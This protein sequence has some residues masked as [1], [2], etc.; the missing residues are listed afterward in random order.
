[1]NDLLKTQALHYNNHGLTN[2]DR[3]ESIALFS[4]ASFLDPKEP[5][6]MWHMAEAQLDLADM[7]AAITTLRKVEYLLKSSNSKLGYFNKRASHLFFQHGEILLDQF[8]IQEAAGMF[9]MAKSMGY[10]LQRM[11]L[12]LAV[13]KMCLGDIDGAIQS[14]YELIQ[15]F[16][17]LAD[18]Y[19]LR[20]RIHR[21]LENPFLVNLDYLRA[22]ELVQ[23]HSALPDLR[24]YILERAVFYR[25]KT[26]EQIQR[27]QYSSALWYCNQAIELDSK[28]W[29]TQLTRGM[30]LSELQDYDDAL[31]DLQIVKANSDRGNE[32]EMLI[33]QH[34]AAIY[35]KFGVLF[36][37]RK[38]YEEAI[39]LFSTALSYSSLDRIILKNR[40]ECFY[41]L[42]EY[43]LAL[44]DFFT[45][46]EMDKSDTDCNLRISLI[47]GDQGLN[48]ISKGWYFEASQ[49]FTNAI[50]HNKENGDFYYER[51]RS[52]YFQGEIDKAREDLIQ[53]LD[54]DETNTK[55]QGLISILSGKPY[56]DGFQPM[57]P[58]KIAK[59][60]EKLSSPE[61]TIARART[62]GTGALAVHTLDPSDVF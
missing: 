15:C 48:A 12:K 35:N 17:E 4:K 56:M 20:A 29:R 59:Q 42:K 37:Q 34:I 41:R 31:E 11:H 61:D 40:A 10:P 55:A 62:D 28:D 21:L 46:L 25:N 7:P 26:S 9:Y 22:R 39:R 32:K 33:N 44:Q 6:Y 1:M 47:Y 24:R 8:R 45:A 5:S 13:C 60:L 53:C 16:P 18:A 14:L 49:T 50:A 2:P 30:L 43:T 57:K 58:E 19:I 36:F 27:K 52:Y 23:D 38:G 51:A 3:I 54:L